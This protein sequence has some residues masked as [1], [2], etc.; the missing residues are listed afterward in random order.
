[1]KRF[2]ITALIRIIKAF[3]YGILGAFLVIV[4]LFLWGLQQRPDLN[5]WHEAN[6]DAEFTVK[7]KVKNF[8]EYLAL[9]EKLFTQLDELVYERILP[10]D[11]FLINRY[12][13]GSKADPNRWSPNWNRTFELESNAPKAGVL[14]L[15]GLSDSPYSMRNLG[16]RLHETGAWVVG[17]RIPGHGTAPSGLVNVHWQDMAAAV[18]LAMHHLQDKVGNQPLYI[19]GYS[20][21]G[22]LAVHYTLETLDDKT[23]PA[24]N[25]L[26]LLSPEI[27]VVKVA[28]LASWQARLGNILKLHKL[29]WNDILPEYEPFKYGSFA[30]NAGDLSYRLTS[31]NRSRL[32]DPTRKEK[33][34]E[35][36]PVLA[37]QS[38]FDKTVSMKAVVEVL[39]KNLPPNG[40]E[41]MLFDINRER[42][43]E[44]L[45]KDDPKSFIE[46][47]FKETSLPFTLSFLTNTTDEAGR[48]VIQSKEAGQTE[49]IETFPNLKWP[50]DVYSLSHVAM[51]FSI[52]DPLYGGDVSVT[53]PGIQ[54]G[55][56]S[57]RGE[58]DILQ[59]PASTMLRLRWNPFY[60]FMEEK[61]LRFLNLT[62]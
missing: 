29:E 11:R 8:Q 31:E 45:L 51:P 46:T 47:Q 62:D 10:E 12:Y 43:L 60:N 15:H 20:N 54:L 59:I 21:G 25:R 18:R 4:F 55:T 37:F 36:P 50:A 9:E 39:F 19:V 28:A 52:D 32:T 49:I 61:L 2:L 33:L 41:L 23:L 17:L 34:K 7:S 13:K 35:F 3:I 58:R 42:N 22:A 30:V 38:A 48:I 6:L 5:V 40:N 27:G 1:M 56:L 24:V 16:K 26:V 53:G 14:L 57:L 44:I